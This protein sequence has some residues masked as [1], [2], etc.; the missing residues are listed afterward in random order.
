LTATDVQGHIFGHGV[1][2]EPTVAEAARLGELHETDYVLASHDDVV[3]LYG[4]DADGSW[5]LITADV[6]AETA[7]EMCLWFDLTH[8]YLDRLST[9]AF[10]Q[11]DHPL[12]HVSTGE[13]GALTIDAARAVSFVVE[14]IRARGLDYPTQG[15]AADR[16]EGGWSVYAPVEVDES[17]PMAFLDLPIGR[18]VFLVSDLGRIKELTSS[19]PPRQAHGLFTAEEAFVRRA[20][21]EERFMAGFRDEVMRLDA[22]HGPAVGSFT[23]VGD[24][25]EE[26]LAA[27][28]SHL[29]T[30][31][32]QQLTRLGPTRWRRFGAVFSYTVSGEIG[33]M[34]F[35]TD[36]P[37]DLRPVPEQIAVLVRRQRHLAARMPA[38]PWSRL[39]LSV[40]GGGEM[41][42]NYDYGDVPLPGEDLLGPEHY[43][44]DL[45]AYPRTDSP[46][47]LAEYIA[48]GR[49]RGAAA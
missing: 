16:F 27:K 47:W 39:L 4:R 31:I 38:G 49:R 2:A 21:A 25:P 26:V 34:R 41:S 32:V 22:G 36:R 1:S 37:L 20:T 48:G 9:G 6:P 17:D 45:V 23:V 35:W 7:A 12:A 29:L 8:H 15:L 42:V 10:D 24:P 28:A 14:R 19:I 46:A 13:D 43:R 40:T 3:S 11:A 18:S 44:N 30:A 33:R 5:T